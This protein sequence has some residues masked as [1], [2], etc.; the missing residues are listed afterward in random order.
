MYIFKKLGG[1][2]CLACKELRTLEGTSYSHSINDY[3]NQGHWNDISIADISGFSYDQVSS[4]LA[5]H[6]VAYW[7]GNKSWIVDFA[8][9]IT[10]Q[11][12]YIYST[13]TAYSGDYCISWFR[14]EAWDSSTKAWITVA[15]FQ[16]GSGSVWDTRLTGLD[17]TVNA[18]LLKETNRLRMSTYGNSYYGGGLSYYTSLTKIGLNVIERIS[19]PERVITQW[20]NVR[21]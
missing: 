8:R 9:P 14:I 1:R 15:Y 4:I 12:F 2:G 6:R 7:L 18:S 13:Y 20:S 17:Q 16:K 5:G 11:S 10:L 19:V 3:I 21:H